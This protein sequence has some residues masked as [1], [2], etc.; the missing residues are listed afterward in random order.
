MH[1]TLGRVPLHKLSQWLTYSLCE[2][3][4]AHGI[5]VDRMNDLTG[6]A[7]Y[8][9]G[10]LF[11]DGGVL[12][13]KH[14]RVLSETHS[15]GSPVIVEWRTLTVALLDRTASE[16]RRLLGVDERDLPLAKVLEGG[17]WSAG[18]QLASEL[19]RDG[20]PPLAIDSDGT[21]F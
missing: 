16:V 18:R 20:T 14:E 21:V 11:V 4:E 3:L 9:N 5:A 6:L 1:P 15:I 10:G 8:R 17:T 19:R 7:E 13:P 2:P 12:I